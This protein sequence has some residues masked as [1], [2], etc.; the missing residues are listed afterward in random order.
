MNCRKSSR[1]AIR[2]N[3]SRFMRLW[4]VAEISN[5]AEIR[6]ST[7]LDRGGVVGKRAEKE[8]QNEMSHRIMPRQVAVS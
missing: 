8:T 2:R 1:N 7:E 4:Q 5:D 3:N 6:G